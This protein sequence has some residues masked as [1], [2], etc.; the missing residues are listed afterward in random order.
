MET[1]HSGLPLNTAATLAIMSQ[2]T[3]TTME[4]WTLPPQVV[5][6]VLVRFGNGDGTFQTAITVPTWHPTSS[7][8]Y[9][10]LF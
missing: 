4:F 2:A 6:G 9:H 7:V 3:S 10:G 5:S 8:N 1:A